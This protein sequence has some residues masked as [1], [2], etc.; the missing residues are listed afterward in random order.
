MLI[1]TYLLLPKTS[2]NCVTIHLEPT[3]TLTSPV[4][5]SSYELDATVLPLQVVS[6]RKVVPVSPPEKRFWPANPASVATLS[7]DEVSQIQAQIKKLHTIQHRN[8]LY[9]PIAT[10]LNTLS[11]AQARANANAQQCSDIAHFPTVVHFLNPGQRLFGDIHNT[12]IKSD[13]VITIRSYAY[14]QQYLEKLRGGG[15]IKLDDSRP[16]YSS[17]VAAGEIEKQNDGSFHLLNYLDAVKRYRPDLDRV[18]GL[19]SCMDGFSVW[20]LNPCQVIKRA[21]KSEDKHG[22]VSWNNPSTISIL[23]RFVLATYAKPILS[24]TLAL[25]PGSTDVWRLSHGNERWNLVPCYAAHGP[26]RMTW[27]APAFKDNAEGVQR[28]VKLYW[29]DKESLHREVDLYARAHGQTPMLV[30]DLAQEGVTHSPTNPSWLG[31]LARVEPDPEGWFP[32]RS[33]EGSV[34]RQ[35]V[36]LLLASSG[37]PLNYLKS[38]VD[39][40]KCMYDLLQSKCLGSVSVGYLM[41]I[42]A[43]QQMNKNGVLH[44][45]ISYG[46]VFCYPEHYIAPGDKGDISGCIYEVL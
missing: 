43:L 45:D 35:L 18:Y 17:L 9:I 28:I 20:Q 31:G 15:T 13:I 33:I 3:M 4:E 7:M 46:N 6:G 16:C 12:E 34:D 40:L 23:Q 14:A 10:I 25:R 42:P 5:M 26:G 27:V 44:R 22:L 1:S 36:G 24:D 21:L 2:A 32:A 11:I 30:Q 29:A 38:D 41:I 8:H 19:F 39:I 37:K